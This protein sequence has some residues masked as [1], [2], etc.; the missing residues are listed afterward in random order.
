[1]AVWELEPNTSS[2]NWEA[3]ILGC[4]K[5][6]SGPSGVIERARS[7]EPSFAL[8]WTVFVIRFATLCLGGLPTGA[9]GDS[10]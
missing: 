10:L 9:A 2:S 7:S 3:V 1:M 4:L 8:P 6:L 5:A